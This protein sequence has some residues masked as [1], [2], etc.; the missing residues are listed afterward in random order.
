[1]RRTFFHLMSALVQRREDDGNVVPVLKD[2]RKLAELRRQEEEALKKAEKFVGVPLRYQLLEVLPTQG[3]AN[4]KLKY[5]MACRKH[6]PEVGGDPEMFLRVSLAYQD[7]MKDFG[8]ETVNKKVR[9]LGN[10]QSCDHELQNYLQERANI[11][12]YI[13]LSTLEDHISQ[14]EEVQLRLGVDVTKRLSDNTDEAMWL[15]ED[16]EKVIEMTG[17]SAVK[18]ALLEDGSVA[19]K[20]AEPLAIGGEATQSLLTSSEARA[21]EC[22]GSKADITTTSSTNSKPIVET[23]VSVDDILCLTAKHNVQ[24]REDV[25][26]IAARVATGV[27]NNTKEKFQVR[28]ESLVAVFIASNIAFLVFAYFDAYMRAKSEEEARPEVK[29]HITTDT[30]LPWWGNDAEYESQVK[31]IFV[32]EWR[33]ARSGARRVQV[34]QEGI[35][36]ESLSTNEKEAL[37]V[38]IF[39]VTTEKL[40]RMKEHAEAQKGRQ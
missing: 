19:V 11:K 15:L 17:V 29:E 14:L 40:R 33:R 13:P 37:D 23:E 21:S 2:Y 22:E 6:H 38:S 8:I 7:C 20:P 3:L 34:F 27:M 10:F 16:I 30:M 18:L 32:D 26:G 4:V 12:E 24:K 36:R 28:F 35:A 5:L 9:N 39:E 31:R 25:A 1:M